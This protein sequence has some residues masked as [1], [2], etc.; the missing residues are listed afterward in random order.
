MTGPRVVIVTG[1]PTALQLPQHPLPPVRSLQGWFSAAFTGGCRAVDACADR[2]APRT[3]ST[4]RSK[5]WSGRSM[6]PVESSI[7][8]PAVTVAAASFTA[9]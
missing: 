1:T 5:S 9:P 3:R 8:S 7:D 4:A 6:S 2:L